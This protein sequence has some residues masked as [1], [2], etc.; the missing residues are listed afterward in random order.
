MKKSII[1]YSPH[2]RKMIGVIIV[3]FISLVIAV[4]LILKWQSY[5]NAIA[6]IASILFALIFLAC[7]RPVIEWRRIR[8]ED[9]H[10]VLQKRFSKPLRFKIS[11][12]IYKVV[13]KGDRV[14]SFR[15]R[16]NNRYVQISPLAYTDEKELAEKILY[17]INKSK[18]AVEVVEA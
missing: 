5:E 11:D 2:P 8:I 15:F 3:M 1:T 16:T 7:V 9:G 14:R 12:S 10:V 6:L 4:W 17:H 13:L 18:V